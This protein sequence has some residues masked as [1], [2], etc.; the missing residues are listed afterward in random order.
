MSLVGFMV[1][2]PASVRQL[3]PGVQR[4]QFLTSPNDTGSDGLV[5]TRARL[6]FLI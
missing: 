2:V 6:I 3:A 4:H 5:K 1:L